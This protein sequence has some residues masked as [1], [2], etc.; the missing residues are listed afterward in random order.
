MLPP[1]RCATDSWH[2]K[3][4]LVS[5]VLVCYYRFVQL[6]RV[7][8]HSF[9]SLSFFDIFLR[10]L[11]CV[12]AIYETYGIRS[13]TLDFSVLYFRKY[14]ARVHSQT[15]K[16]IVS[17]ESFNAVPWLCLKRLFSRWS[18]GLSV[19]F[20]E[21]AVGCHI[22]FGCV[23][24]G[25]GYYTYWAL[26]HMLSFFV[27]RYRLWNVWIP[28]NSTLPRSTYYTV[29]EKIR[30]FNFGSAGPFGGRR[31]L[32]VVRL[33]STHDLVWPYVVLWRSRF[34]GHGRQSSLFHALGPSSWVMP[35]PLHS[36]LRH[37][38]RKVSHSK[39]PQFYW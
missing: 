12:C 22:G 8:I 39:R 7:R 27:V 31:R 17:A 16:K 29:T 25:A 30:S 20:N 26:A 38:I 37:V 6:S 36:C 2:S 32:A 1:I 33:I 5:L 19:C 15:T 11:M 14:I 34:Q 35:L 3:T 4:C 24:F 23:N 21:Q 18:H 28:S 13:F 10:I 9:M